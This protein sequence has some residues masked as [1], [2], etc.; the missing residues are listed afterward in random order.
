[1]RPTLPY[2]LLSIGMISGCSDT[3]APTDTAPKAA[4]A[5]TVAPKADPATPPNYDKAGFVTKLVDK[6]LWVFR[7]GSPELAE[8]EKTGDLGKQAMLIGAGLNGITLK[9]PDRDTIDAYLNAPSTGGDPFP[10]K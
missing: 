4:P 8:F 1:M 5:E 6:R 3:T 10:K 2:L 7:A 9:G